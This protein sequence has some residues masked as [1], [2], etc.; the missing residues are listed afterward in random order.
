MLNVRGWSLCMLLSEF[1]SFRLSSFCCLSVGLF[2]TLTGAAGFP[3]FPGVAGPDLCF[4]TFFLN[5][6]FDGFLMVLASILDDC[7]DDFPMFF[8]SLVR[9]LFFMFL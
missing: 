7:F 1:L 6:F 4:S 9:D 8:A 2:V 5:R 3:G